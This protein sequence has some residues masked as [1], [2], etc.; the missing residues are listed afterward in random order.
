MDVLSGTRGWSWRVI[1]LAGRLLTACWSGTVCGTHQF[2]PCY[3]ERGSFWLGSNHGSHLISISL[4]SGRGRFC[5][6]YCRVMRHL[7]SVCF[8][9]CLHRTHIKTQPGEEKKTIS[10]FL[11]WLC[12]RRRFSKGKG[13]F[14][15]QCPPSFCFLSLLL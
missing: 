15:K 6:R 11:I 4:L 2:V 14:L 12:L 1:V 8:P 9:H 3:C 7:G 10:L 13:L 5:E